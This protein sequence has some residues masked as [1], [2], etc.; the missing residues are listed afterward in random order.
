MRFVKLMISAK[1]LI[2]VVFK[3]SLK[4]IL[5]TKASEDATRTRIKHEN[6]TK[7]L[8]SPCIKLLQAL[9]FTRLCVRMC[10]ILDKTLWRSISID[11]IMDLRYHLIQL[12]LSVFLDLHLLW[13]H[14]LWMHLLKVNKYVNIRLLKIL[15]FIETIGTIVK[16]IAI[17]TF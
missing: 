3:C 1:L 5:W 11:H 14:L 10:S 2:T 17:L 15:S 7:M 8:V 6:D 4:P 13:M 9:M 12:L 16:C